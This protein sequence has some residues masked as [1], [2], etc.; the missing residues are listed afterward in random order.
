MAK[1]ER[2]GAFSVTVNADQG[3][4][5]LGQVLTKDMDIADYFR[6]MCSVG[7]V[8]LGMDDD[9]IVAIAK[10]IPFT[11]TEGEDPALR[12][13]SDWEVEVCTTLESRNKPN[14]DDRSSRDA[15]PDQRSITDVRIAS[16]SVAGLIGEKFDANENFRNVLHTAAYATEV[17]KASPLRLLL[18]TFDIYG[19]TVDNEGN[20][21]DIEHSRM[22]DEIPHPSAIITKDSEYWKKHGKVLPAD[23]NKFS[24]YP[25][26]VGKDL[27]KYDWFAEMFAATAE[28]KAIEA[29]VKEWQLAREGKGK[30][31][32]GRYANKLQDEVV[33]KLALW[34]LRWSTGVKFLRMAIEACYQWRDILTLM[35]GKIGVQLGMEGHGTEKAQVS[36]GFTTI[37]IYNA[38]A[39]GRTLSQALTI[40]GFNNLDVYKAIEKGGTFVDLRDSSQSGARE[41]D[42]SGLWDEGTIKI[43]GVLDNLPQIADWFAIPQNTGELMAKCDAKD[44][45]TRER[46]EEAENTIL[47]GMKWY[48]AMSRFAA[49]YAAIAMDIEAKRA[50][51][52]RAAS[53]AVQA[54]IKAVA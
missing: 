5:E 43:D 30:T 31:P 1:F 28:G 4:Y 3:D 50:E 13:S 21:K 34:K 48:H 36:E 15:L 12:G 45:A 18:S 52:N 53:D 9:Q 20:V 40:S 37:V 23:Q 46:T 14:S 25:K 29:E 17:V 38:V 26:L 11:V 7:D 49:K 16:G 22:F 33:N 32:T 51:E 8:V 54:K 35:H 47:A 2:K 42:D 24:E 10:S 19:L 6:E 41:T 27:V 44:K 39:K